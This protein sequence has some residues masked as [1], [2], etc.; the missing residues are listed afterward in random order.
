MNDMHEKDG[1]ENKSII[2]IAVG[3]FALVFVVFLLCVSTAVYADPQGKGDTENG[4]GAPGNGTGAPGNGTGAPGNGTGAPAETASGPAVNIH[5]TYISTLTTTPT[6]TATPTPSA[7]PTPTAPPA[8]TLEEVERS[9]DVSPTPT[10]YTTEIRAFYDGSTVNVGE[11]IDL[12]KLRVIECFSDGSKTDLSSQEYE[13]SSRLVE[14]DGVNTFVAI[15]GKFTSIFRVLGRKPSRIVA[16]CEA[17]FCSIGNMPHRSLFKVTCIYSDGTMGDVTDF[18]IEPDLITS[19][20]ENKVRIIYQDLS[21]EVVLV[22]RE[23]PAITSLAVKYVKPS[24]CA[25]SI[26]SKDD[27]EVS[28]VYADATTETITNF[29]LLQEKFS[30]TGIQKLG[31][32]YQGITKEIEIEVLENKPVKLRAEYIGKAIIVGRDFRRE[33][34]KVYVEYMNGD[35]KETDEY[36]F[37][38]PKIHYI[39]DNEVQIY[40]GNDLSTSVT[41]VGTVVDEPDFDYVSKLTA[42]NGKRK[43]TI[44]TAIPRYLSKNCMFTRS[45]KKS[46]MKKAYRKLGLKKGYYIAFTYGFKDDNDE[47]ELP[48]TVRITIPKKYDM[49]KTFLFY[50]P[51]RKSVLGM[52]NK[53]VI[54]DRTFETV[55]FKTG[56]YMLVYSEYFNEDEEEEE[57]FAESDYLD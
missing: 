39:G 5:P 3:M 26:I 30:E 12:S 41:I 45:I 15:Y 7:T 49:D 18:K 50:S 1:F 34:L 53:T 29:V 27:L 8:P 47:V 43:L 10:P 21:C 23:S 20:G 25:D 22:G 55:L 19:L 16:T 11:E 42:T 40:Y 35:E 13:L 17:R 52:T 44:K 36:T 48:V 6:P 54:S 2:Y 24:L 28:A 57:E 38:S 9:A 33:D 51:D 14:K 56:T 32:S 37:H 4:T 46:V 31:V